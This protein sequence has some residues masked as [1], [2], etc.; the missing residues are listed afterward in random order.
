MTPS[1]R[2]VRSL[3][4]HLDFD[5][6]PLPVNVSGLVAACAMSAP[7]YRDLVVDLQVASLVVVETTTRRDPFDLAIEICRAASGDPV[8]SLVA[9]TQALGLVEAQVS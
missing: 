6:S 5:R 3:Q 4:G 8:L 7:E 1:D 9:A 2:D